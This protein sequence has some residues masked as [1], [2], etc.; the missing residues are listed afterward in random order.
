MLPL[1]WGGRVWL[2]PLRTSQTYA[3]AIWA[4]LTA[5]GFSSQLHSRLLV[6]LSGGCRGGALRTQLTPQTSATFFPTPPPPRFESPPQS[7]KG[8]ARQG[9]ERSFFPC[10]VVPSQQNVGKCLLLYSSSESAKTRLGH[11]PFAVCWC[12]TQT[13]ENAT[14]KTAT[15]LQNPAFC[16]FAPSCAGKNAWKWTQSRTWQQA[17]TPTNALCRRLL[18]FFFRHHVWVG[19]LVLALVNEVIYSYCFSLFCVNI[20]IL[21]WSEPL[22]CKCVQ[23]CVECTSDR[24]VSE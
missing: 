21:M 17:E 4:G 8:E 24:N 6:L 9:A 22:D 12:E 14:E 23:A 18:C 7:T 20:F 13:A 5:S 10:F 1:S 15:L 11:P 3:A 19:V 2:P 16:P